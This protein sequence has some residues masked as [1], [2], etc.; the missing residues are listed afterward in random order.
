[1]AVPHVPRSGC[2]DRPVSTAKEPRRE[3]RACRRGGTPLSGR[4]RPL[5]QDQVRGSWRVAR[6]LPIEETT[7]RAQSGRARFP[8]LCVLST[9]A[10]FHGSRRAIHAELLAPNG[11]SQAAEHPLLAPRRKVR[12][13]NDVDRYCGYKRRSESIVACVLVTL[14][15]LPKRVESRAADHLIRIEQ[16]TCD[17]LVVLHKRPDQVGL[18]FQVI[19]KPPCEIPDAMGS[20]VDRHSTTP[21]RPDSAKGSDRYLSTSIEGLARHRRPIME[22]ARQ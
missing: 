21:E 6:R 7:L 15:V 10:A 11:G 12:H 14:S 9:S 20:I 18:V 4:L 3:D 17:E 19:D 5:R 1:M 16:S 2:Q 22:G 8:T 13:R